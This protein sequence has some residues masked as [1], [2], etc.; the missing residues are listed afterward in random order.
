MPCPSLWLAGRTCRLF[1]HPPAP[2]AV[3]G[4]P[5]PSSRSSDWTPPLISHALLVRPSLSR[6]VY[7]I[8]SLYVFTASVCNLASGISSLISN[9]SCL[10]LSCPSGVNPPSQSGGAPTPGLPVLSPRGFPTTGA[11]VSPRRH[12]KPL[13]VLVCETPPYRFAPSLY[14]SCSYLVLGGPS[15]P[16]AKHSISA[17]R[18]HRPGYLNLHPVSS[19]PQFR[20]HRLCVW[21]SLF[22]CAWRGLR[23]RTGILT[24]PLVP[25]G[26]DDRRSP[27]E[28]LLLSHL[29]PP[30]KPCRTLNLSRSKS[31]SLITPLM[32]PFTQWRNDMRFVCL[33]PIG[34]LPSSHQSALHDSDDSSLGN[35]SIFSPAPPN[36]CIGRGQGLSLTLRLT[37][38]SQPLQYLP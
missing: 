24:R 23:H 11:S 34:S 36:A 35:L 17:L 25:I 30:P 5:Q 29:S 2:P 9:S 3:A 8:S 4:E 33:S 37:G 6:I 12:H 13:R 15:A 26:G 20:S 10:L 18:G 19:G 1:V 31:S 16:V 28:G 14:I 7:C 32:P 21:L 22:T 38:P 27:P